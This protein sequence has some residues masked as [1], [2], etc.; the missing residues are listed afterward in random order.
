MA[1]WRLAVHALDR[2]GPPMLALSFLRWAR[3]HRPDASFDLVAFR[4]GDLVDS[5]VEL[6]PVHVVLDPSE[7]WDHDN[8]PHH[9]VTE[10]RERLARLPE[11]DA[12][13]LVSV[14][15]CQV[16]PLLQDDRPVV[17]WSVEQGED[18]HWI[19]A[20]LG[21][22]DSTRRWLA[23][24]GGT[25]DALGAR[26]PIDTQITVCD[27]FVDT[28]RSL[29]PA[30]V[31]NCRV[32]QGVG[33]GDVLVIGAG[34]GTARKGIDLFMEVAAAA[35]R[36]GLDHVYFSW[37]GGEND[38][39]HWRV[40]AESRR[41]RI[42]RLRWFGTVTDVDRWLAAADVFLHTARLD[43]F[44]LVCLHAAAVGTPVVSFRGAGG[45][46][47]MFGDTF[48]GPQ[49]PDVDGTVDVLEQLTDPLHRAF[50]GRRQQRVVSARFT[51]VH[52]APSVMAELEAAAQAASSASPTPR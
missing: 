7:M 1:H 5:M 49:Y 45:T 22:A 47:E 46:E 18:L 9:R 28:P 40:R 52:A 25:A 30:L 42:S 41:L 29:S 15:A 2:T 20:P 13:L 35:G 51:S 8:P 11:P 10:L 4:G 34:I 21:L 17:V 33:D 14:S 16:L 44:P 38:E 37:L 32:A 19:D 43:A 27:E 39:L 48:L 3:K 6:A 23:G 31:A 12:T 50:C 36:R 24:P 26:L